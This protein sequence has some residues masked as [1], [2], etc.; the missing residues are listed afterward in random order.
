MNFME[1]MYNY[2]W[3]KYIKYNN[4]YNNKIYNN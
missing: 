4:K 2:Y 1:K 3:H